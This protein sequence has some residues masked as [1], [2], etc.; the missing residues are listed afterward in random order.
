[1]CIVFLWNTYCQN[2]CQSFFQAS[3]C[4]YPSINVHETWH[5]YS[6]LVF[7]LFMSGPTWCINM[8]KCSPNSARQKGNPSCPI[9]VQSL[10]SNNLPNQRE[11]KRLTVG[12]LHRQSRHV[13]TKE[14][15]HKCLHSCQTKANGGNLKG[16]YNQAFFY[17]T[18]Y[19]IILYLCFKSSCKLAIHD[20][21]ESFLHSIFFNN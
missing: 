11:Q 17:C 4:I 6:T 8:A 5:F 7:T 12:P 20:K 1:M 10:G 21:T 2:Q 3:W 16:E 19:V 14:P 9:I 15:A 13:Q 18:R